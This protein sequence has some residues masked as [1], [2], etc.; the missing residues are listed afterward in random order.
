MKFSAPTKL[1]SKS[2]H[3]GFNILPPMKLNMDPKKP[4]VSKLASSPYFQVGTPFSGEAS[5]NFPGSCTLPETNSSHLKMMVWKMISL[6]QGCILRFHVNLLGCPGVLG[7]FWGMAHVQGLLVSGSVT[8][9]RLL[10]FN[11]LH[12]KLRAGKGKSS[13]QSTNCCWLPAASFWGL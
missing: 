2:C 7:F 11:F 13:T 6:F 9:V 3:S 12:R 10:T 8:I 1:T 4:W 5:K